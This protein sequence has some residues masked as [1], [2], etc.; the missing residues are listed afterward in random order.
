MN[1][2]ERRPTKSD[3]LDESAEFLA[4]RRAR[5]WHWPVAAASL[6]LLEALFLVWLAANFEYLSECW[7][8]MREMELGALDVAPW[9]SLSVM[10]PFWVG[11]GIAGYT[12]IIYLIIRVLCLERR[13]LREIAG[14]AEGRGRD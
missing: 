3:Q 9:Q 2:R 7:G 12:F 14:A 5:L 10:I 11:L 13:Y 1:A 8:V 6:A 4:R